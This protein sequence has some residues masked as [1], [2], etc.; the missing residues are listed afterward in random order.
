M[1]VLIVAKPLC[2]PC[3]DGLD[4]LD[5]IL[6]ALHLLTQAVGHVLRYVPAQRLQRRLDLS[7]QSVLASRK[8]RPELVEQPTQRIALHGLHLH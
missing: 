1:H 2:K 4:V 8:R 5:Q 7:H 3:L 6:D